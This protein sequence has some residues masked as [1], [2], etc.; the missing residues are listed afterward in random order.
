MSSINEALFEC[1]NTKSTWGH[2]SNLWFRALN[3]RYP[4]LNKRKKLDIDEWE[5]LMSHESAAVETLGF[6]FHPY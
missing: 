4:S 5:D 6:L 1:R 2:H 3:M